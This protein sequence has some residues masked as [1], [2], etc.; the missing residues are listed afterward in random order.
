MKRIVAGIVLS[1]LAAG[2]HTFMRVA[3]NYEDLPVEDLR[4]VAKE[5]ERAVHEKNR[6]PQ[7][8]NR[9]SVRVDTDEIRQAIRARAARAHLIEGFL[10][11]GHL[12]EAN[13]G[14]VEILRTREYKRFGTARDRD[15]N[16]QLVIEENAN[17][18]ALYEGI[19]KAG[20][21]SPRT[22]PGVQRIFYE[23]R[24]EFLADGTKVEDE[25][26]NVAYKG[27]APAQP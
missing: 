25:N 22:L 24:M 10:A 18:W 26:G 16:A 20:N 11:T 14:L 21:F 13:N 5:I 17:R 2:C 3:P 6:E 4:T 23:V 8:A 15:R 9:G 1:C 12:M 27:G 19:V 7:I